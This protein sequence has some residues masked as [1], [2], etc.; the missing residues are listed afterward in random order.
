MMAGGSMGY[1]FDQAKGRAVGSVIRMN[2]DMLGLTLAV[3]EVVTERI[4]PKHKML[5]TR[6]P[7]RM[8]VIDAYR[9]GFELEPVG[10]NS[11]LRVFIDYNLPPGPLA[12]LA[13]VPAHLYARWCVEQMADAATERFGSVLDMDQ[14]PERTD[15]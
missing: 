13:R 12:C 15:A 2:G 8:F 11:A 4:P 5:E 10:A 7:Q 14:A 3:E 6:G 9:L 1:Q